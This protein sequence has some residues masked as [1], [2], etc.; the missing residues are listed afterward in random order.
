MKEGT[1]ALAAEYVPLVVPQDAKERWAMIVRAATRPLPADRD[2]ELMGDGDFLEKRPSGIPGAGFGLFTTKRL[3]PGEFIA[4]Y[5]GPG[6]VNSDDEDSSYCVSAVDEKTRIDYLGGVDWITKSASWCAAACVN[7]GRHTPGFKVNAQL[8]YVFPRSS[9]SSRTTSLIA[10]DEIGAG[11]E[12]FLDYGEAYWA[13]LTQSILAPSPAAEPRQPSPFI[14][15]RPDPLLVAN[16]PEVLPPLKKKRVPSLADLVASKKGDPTF[17]AAALVLSYAF[18]EYLPWEEGKS[19]IDSTDAVAENLLNLVIRTEP[20]RETLARMRTECMPYTDHTDHQTLIPLKLADYMQMASPAKQ[21]VTC[22][23]G[24]SELAGS[25]AGMRHLRPFFKKAAHNPDRPWTEI[26]SRFYRMVY[27]YI[28]L[29]SPNWTTEKSATFRETGGQSDQ[30][31]MLAER[32]VV[33][34]LLRSSQRVEWYT[35]LTAIPTLFVNKHT[36]VDDGGFSFEG[37]AGEE[38]EN[39]AFLT[40]NQLQWL[41]LTMHTVLIGHRLTWK[42]TTSPS[43][44]FGWTSPTAFLGP[45]VNYTFV[46]YNGDAQLR[47][48]LKTEQRLPMMKTSELVPVPLSESLE[49]YTEKHIQR[50]IDDVVQWL[51]KAPSVLRNFNPDRYLDFRTIF[52]DLACQVGRLDGLIK[53]YPRDERFVPLAVLLPTPE[54]NWWDSY[55]TEDPFLADEDNYPSEDPPTFQ[56]VPGIHWLIDFLGLQGLKAGNGNPRRNLFKSG[57]EPVE[58]LQLWPGQ[59]SAPV[60][61]VNQWQANA[62]TILRMES[63]GDA[64]RAESIGR[65]DCLIILTILGTN[66]YVRDAVLFLAL[67][68]HLVEDRVVILH[69]NRTAMIGRLGFMPAAE[70]VWIATAAKLFRQMRQIDPLLRLAPNPFFCDPDEVKAALEKAGV[71]SLRP[72]TH[73][74]DLSPLRVLGGDSAPL[75][76]LLSEIDTDEEAIVHLAQVYAWIGSICLNPEDADPEALLTGLYR[77]A[78]ARR[79]SLPEKINDIRVFTLSLFS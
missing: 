55:N 41:L 7:D 23:N 73:S 48:S 5:C 30:A 79:T 63:S 14:P 56:R 4:W 16:A 17:V 39:R 9:V 51:G 19:Q 71:Y 25:S 26:V 21:I 78:A 61:D 43:K 59:R 29:P 24:K 2:F 54:S 22:A 37:L 76:E 77:A 35:S 10:L 75:E 34:T 70:N 46:L 40:A 45:R 57:G 64:A 47:L 32:Q 6:L 60:L 20:T 8:A 62:P 28:V 52:F 65:S 15:G 31:A 66:E 27:D 33:N 68:Q 67:A 3:E 12:I 1:M 42:P 49:A 53:A 44:L 72:S 58:P 69:S 11:T 13:S 36:T 18:S 38:E 74:I 50:Y